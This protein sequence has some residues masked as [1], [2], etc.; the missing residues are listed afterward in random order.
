MVENGRNRQCEMSV[1]VEF[2]LFGLMIETV[3]IASITR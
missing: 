3:E 1:F 2:N